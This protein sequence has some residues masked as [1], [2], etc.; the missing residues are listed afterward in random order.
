MLLAPRVTMEPQVP[1]DLMV[2]QELLALM[3]PREKRETLAHEVSKY[4]NDEY[5]LQFL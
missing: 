5:I 3:V 4:S 2:L 1:R